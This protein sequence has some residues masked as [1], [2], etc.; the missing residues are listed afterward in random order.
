MSLVFKNLRCTSGSVCFV[1]QVEPGRSSS[2]AFAMK[3]TL[4]SFLLFFLLV[5]R[6]LSAQDPVFSQFYADALGLNPALTGVTEAPHLALNYRSQWTNWNGGTAY[7]TYAA[8]YDQFIGGLNSGL[9]FSF[10]ADDQ[11]V[12]LVKTTRV[13]GT[14]S[15]RVRVRGELFLQFGLEAGLGQ[16]SYDWDRL[17]FLDQID[18]RNGPT[19]VNG[20]LLPTAEQRPELAQLSYFDV[21]TGLVAYLPKGYAGVTLRHLNRPAL[22]ILGKNS[23]LIEGLPVFFSLHAGWNISLKKGNKGRDAAFLSPNLL[24]VKQAAQGQVSGGMYAGFGS[25]FTGLWYRHAFNNPD[26]L[27]LSAGLRKGVFKFG[28]STDLTISQL[29]DYRPGMVHELSIGIYLSES[30]SWKRNRRSNRYNN[31]FDLF[32]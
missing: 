27:I 28:Y 6:Q 20:N 13:K 4:L 10:S 14:Y 18:P 1:E 24:F 9:G 15:Y 5:S 31:C 29:A 32:R 8:A 26:A 16:M 22:E 21:G 17:V 7:L 11:G 25:F 30:E 19:D 12:G 2:N 23:N 3:K